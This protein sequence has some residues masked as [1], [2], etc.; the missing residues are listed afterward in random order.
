MKAFLRY[1]SRHNLQLENGRLRLN[2][3]M[4]S[5][6]NRDGSRTRRWSEP[7]WVFR[8]R[9]RWFAFAGRQRCGRR[10]ES[11]HGRTDEALPD[12]WDL[13]PDGN[14][15]C[16]YC[17]S[18][19]LDDLMEICRKTLVDD[20]FGVETTDKRYKFYIRQPGVRNASEGAL[21][22]Y[23]AHVPANPSEAD[24]RLFANACRLTQKRWSARWNAEHPK[25]P[26]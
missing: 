22:F 25:A 3:I 20:R 11:F 19:H 14:R 2:P 1:N 24:Q 6:H 4:S 21:K 26:V 16:S 17:G 10:G 13:G 8:L 18:I 7:L 9:Q 5:S 15:T 12:T 23:T